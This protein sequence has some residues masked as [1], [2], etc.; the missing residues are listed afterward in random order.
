MIKKIKISIFFILISLISW[1]QLGYEYKP[2]DLFI[3]IP[4]TI[5]NV[6]DDD[7][8]HIFECNYYQY[9]FK[10]MIN[11]SDNKWIVNETTCKDIHKGNFP[12]FQFCELIDVYKSAKENKLLSI[13]TS[14]S[15]QVFAKIFEKIEAK[16]RFFAVSKT[17]NQFEIEAILETDYGMKVFVKLND[18]SKSLPYYLKLENGEY[19]FYATHDSL[20]SSVNVLLGFY[21]LK[22]NEIQVAG[23]IDKDGKFNRID[24]CPCTKNVLQKNSD[25]DKFGDECDNCPLVG[26][27]SQEDSDKDGVGDKCDN[28]ISSTNPDQLNNDGDLFG[29]KCDNCPEMKNDDQKDTDNDKVGDVC[30]NCKEISNTNQKDTDAD[31]FGDACDTCP[32]KPNKDQK[33]DCN[34]IKTKEK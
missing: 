34:K 32:D 9:D 20:V 12:F 6:L 26:N 13:Y 21:F 24:N 2:I 10:G 14:E 22:A 1:A 16:E 4:D 31:G 28:C 23:D 5:P 19:K 3:S 30:D 18:N 17:V 8:N 27:N 25:S 7:K 33:I 15:A 29:N 11:T